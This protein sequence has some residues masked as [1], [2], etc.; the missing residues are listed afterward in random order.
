MAKTSRDAYRHMRGWGEFFRD[1]K[2]VTLALIDEFVS[3][4][5][6]TKYLKQSFERLINRGLINKKGSVF[7]ASRKGLR[8]FRKNSKKNLSSDIW[9]G[10]WRLVSFDV[11]GGYNQKRD[12]LR[13]MLKDF[14]FYRLQ[15]SVWISPD[16]KDDFWRVLVDSE[17][18][19]YCK[20]MLVEILE[21]DIDLKKQFGLN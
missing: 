21:G 3:K 1:G 13:R 14:D 6:K 20:V 9:D 4:Y 17:L 8:F 18:D 19:K 11:P 12:E 10:K 16:M 7:V 15:R 2:A 5:K